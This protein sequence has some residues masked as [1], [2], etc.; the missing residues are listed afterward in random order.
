MTNSRGLVIA[1]V[2]HSLIISVMIRIL[3]RCIEYEHLIIIII[4][5]IIIIKK[6]EYLV[7]SNRT[8]KKLFSTMQRCGSPIM[9]RVKLTEWIKFYLVRFVRPT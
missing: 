6:Y 3:Y 8:F 7:G 5:I 2:L 9:Q 1:N 4:I